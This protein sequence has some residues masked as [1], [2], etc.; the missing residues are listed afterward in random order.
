M[1]QPVGLGAALTIFV[2]SVLAM[3][4]VTGAVTLT[5]EAVAAINLVVVNGVVLGG[6]LYSYMRSTPTAAP[7]LKEGTQVKV[8]DASGTRVGTT[9]VS[10][11]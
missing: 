10:K 2:N 7:T 1:T 8:T 5:S 11:D 6:A 4:V 9:T 3:L